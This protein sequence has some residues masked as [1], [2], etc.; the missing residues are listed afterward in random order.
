MNYLILLPAA[1]FLGLSYFYHNKYKKLQNTGKIPVLVTA[2]R[3]T[4]IFLV[5]GLSVAI[6][7]I[8][9][10]FIGSN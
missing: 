5:L 3:N 7:F 9:V 4:N 10:T 8:C 2:R 6:L 1:G